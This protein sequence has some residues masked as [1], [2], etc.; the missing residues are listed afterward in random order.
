MLCGS[1]LVIG[2]P[3]IDMLVSLAVVITITLDKSITLIVKEF[4]F[5]GFHNTIVDS[6]A[7]EI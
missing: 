1:K 5:N 7:F 6:V 2:F 4:Q 3:W